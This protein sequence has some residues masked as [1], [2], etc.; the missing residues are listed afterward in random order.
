[1]KYIATRYEYLNEQLEKSNSRYKLLSFDEEDNEDL[2][3]Y[4]IDEYDAADRALEIAKNG[5]VTILR[6]KRLSGVLVD[7]KSSSVIGAI[8]ISDSSDVFSFD[9]AIDTSYQNMGL[10]NILIKSVISEY[11]NQKEMY[12]DMGDE[13]KMEV[14]VIN[15]KLAQ[16]LTKKYK[17]YVVAELS[18]N[19]VLMSID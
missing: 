11:R 3:A 17:F 8:W 12:D 4:N 6:D 18:Q 5:G 9:M 2:K 19:R 13:F 14:D 15:P 1:M 10:S 7:T 16:I